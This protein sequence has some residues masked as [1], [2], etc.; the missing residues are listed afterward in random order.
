MKRNRVFLLLFVACLLYSCSSHHKLALRDSQT[1][2]FITELALNYWDLNYSFPISYQQSRDTEAWFF[3]QY[4]TIDSLLLSHSSEIKYLDND[5]TLIITYY[6]DTLTFVDLPCSCDYTDNIPNGPRAFDNFNNQILN[7]Y[8]QIDDNVY[9]IHLSHDLAKKMHH[10]IEEKMNRSGYFRVSDVEK[11][12]PQYLLIEYL[13]TSDSIHLI[14]A[15]EKYSYY[16]YEE[17]ATILRSVFYEYCNINHVSRLLT[18]VN[19]YLI[20]SKD[21]IRYESLSE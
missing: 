14:K 15:C 16:F 1:I 13:S 3:T 19:V 10:I 9:A 2:N 8:I 11:R 17:Y 5:T 21:S 7:D 4:A 18:P 12:Y 20:A 6:D